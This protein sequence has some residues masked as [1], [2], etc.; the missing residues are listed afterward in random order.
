[1]NFVQERG[2]LK[3]SGKL[4]YPLWDGKASPVVVTCRTVGGVTCYLFWENAE[5]VRSVAAL[6]E[7]TVKRPISGGDWFVGRS[8]P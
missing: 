4:L 5:T 8:K 6:S 2:T 1:M 7:I 3:D